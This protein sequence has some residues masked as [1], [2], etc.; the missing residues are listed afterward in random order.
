MPK[1]T[2]HVAVVIHREDMSASAAAHLRTLW[3]CSLA[4]RTRWRYSRVAFHIKCLGRE[5][6]D[7]SRRNPAVASQHWKVNTLLPSPALSHSK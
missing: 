4:S 1:D 2:L 5:S 3:K 6:S 7:H